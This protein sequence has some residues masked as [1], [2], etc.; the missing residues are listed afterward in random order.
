[1]SEQAKQYL[2][3]GPAWIGDM[4]MAQSLFIDIKQREPNSSIDV[5]APTWT[6]ALIDRM[7]EVRKLIPADFIHGKLSLGMRYQIGK[8]LRQEA[9]THAITLPN[10]IKSAL[11]PAFAKIPVRTGF[12][13]EQR[14]GLLTDIRK[15][16]KSKL[17][18]T[19]QRFISHGLDK[20]APVRSIDSIPA[21]LLTSKEIDVQSVLA[22][23][24]LSLD[25]KALVLCPGAE[26]GISKQWP[27]GYYAEV[28]QYYLSLG[29]QIW[30]MGSEKDVDICEAINQTSSNSCITLAGKTS[31]PEA[32]DLISQAN[33]VVSND[34][35]LM[36]I[37]AALQAPLIAIYGSTDPGHTPP[38]SE[39]HSVLRLGLECSP[40]FKRECPLGHLNCLKDLSSQQ[41]INA[42]EGLLQ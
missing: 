3:I 38:L 4:V 1:M 35:G 31:L 19:V 5:L 24:R 34:S 22:K 36:H 42:A 29:W 37:A 41:V 17:P 16:N 10:S 12:I 13:G 20:N 33:L 40:C 8:K 7:P 2:I 39:N 32:V 9:Y 28:A 18:M 23:F 26:F 27:K 25:K 6:A 14:W 15:L 11:V 21:P 30:L